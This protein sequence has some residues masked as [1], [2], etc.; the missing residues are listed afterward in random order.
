MLIRFVI[1]S[2]DPNSGR[3]QGLFQAADGLCNSG[4]LSDADAT[5]LQSIEDWFEEHLPTPSQ[6]SISKRPHGKEQA[7]SW[8]KLSAHDHIDRMRIIQRILEG[9]DIAVQ[10]I[11]TDRPG[12]VVYEDEFQIAAYP[13]ADTPT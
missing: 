9:C 6:L 7:I 11:K 13:F 4:R 10:V 1:R 3:R 8:F 5:E 2:L 12:Y